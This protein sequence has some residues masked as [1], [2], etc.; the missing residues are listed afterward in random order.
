MKGVLAHLRIHGAVHALWMISLLIL[1]IAAL[2]LMMPDGKSVGDYIAF[3]TSIASLVL[4]VVAIGHSLISGQSFAETVGSL[5]SSA[6]DVK[7]A[8]TNVCE[9]SNI[10]SGQSERLLLE[11]GALPPAVKAISD[12]LDAQFAPSQQSIPANGELQLD[13]QENVFSGPMP[14]GLRLAIYSMIR[15]FSTGKPIVTEQFKISQVWQSW[16]S[17]SLG[18]L[19]IVKPAGIDL[20]FESQGI[21]VSSLGSLDAAKIERGARDIFQASIPELLLAV[22]QYF[23]GGDLDTK[24]TASEEK[25]VVD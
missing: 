17:G 12:K 23:V 21:V 5:K 1:V 18:T 4:A 11:F 8:A 20:K 2:I 24:T 6:D 13:G 7:N 3:A 14:N 22:D 15:S 9:V 19:L 16:I 25:V 10:L